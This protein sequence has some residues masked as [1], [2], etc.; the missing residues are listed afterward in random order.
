VADDQWVDET[1]DG[2]LVDGLAPTD[3][4]ETSLRE[5]GEMSGRAEITKG[6]DELASVL[7]ASIEYSDAVE[8]PLEQHLT[9]GRV[10]IKVRRSVFD[11]LTQ[12]TGLAIAIA[13]HNPAGVVPGLQLLRTL[14]NAVSLLTPEELV[15]LRNV[16][17]AQRAEEPLAIATLDEAGKQLLA[18]GVIVEEDGRARIEF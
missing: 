2:T 7:G 17:S 11:F 3:L 9:V 18:R 12:V 4:D 15:S 13:L 6:L 8:G 16:V 10:H 14:R 1:W 5:F